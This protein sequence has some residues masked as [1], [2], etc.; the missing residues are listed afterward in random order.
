M[1]CSGSRAR[2]RAQFVTL[3][4]CV[5]QANRTLA[6]VHSGSRGFEAALVCSR[7]GG[8]L[9]GSSLVTPM[10]IV[11]AATALAATAMLVVMVS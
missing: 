5:E 4:A 6:C 8:G 7:R 1:R 2:L 9:F 11:F 10:Q 3:E